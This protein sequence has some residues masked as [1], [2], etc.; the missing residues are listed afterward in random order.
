[1]IK[2]TIYIERRGLERTKKK[3]FSQNL[4]IVKTSYRLLKKIKKKV[5]NLFH[6][7]SNFDL[8][9]VTWYLVQF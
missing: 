5:N 6:F 3:F 8:E 4:I 9:M 7:L 1:M 2:V